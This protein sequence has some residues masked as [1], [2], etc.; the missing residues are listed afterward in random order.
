[1][2]A[3]RNSLPGNAAA[4]PA[5]D[6]DRTENDLLAAAKAGNGDAFAA[7]AEKYRPLLESAVAQYRDELSVQDLEDLG[8]EA[9]LAFHRA[10]ASFEPENGRASLGLYA[11]TCINN[12]LVSAIRRLTRLNARDA[13]LSLDD[14]TMAD[15]PAEE[16]DPAGAVI[17]RESARE[18]RRRISEALSPYENT[19]WWLHFSGKTPAEIAAETGKNAKSVDNA[20]VR[21]RKKLRMLL[22]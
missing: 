1:M 14:E 20:L 17:E 21:I 13:V 3:N 15:L 9:L 8:Q 11:R 22:S 10:V 2:N 19:V 4:R 5:R 16:P 12:A 7:L 18:L 6:T